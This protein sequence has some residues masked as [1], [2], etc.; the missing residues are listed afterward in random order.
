MRNTTSIQDIKTI[1]IQF[2]DTATGIKIDNKTETV[3]VKDL[4]AKHRTRKVKK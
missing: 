2:Q 4:L 3:W 1:T